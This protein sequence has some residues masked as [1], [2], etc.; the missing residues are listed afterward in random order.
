MVGTCNDIDQLVTT[1]FMNEHFEDFSSQCIDMV[2]AKRK[3][4][5]EYYIF[6][7]AYTKTKDTLYK[8][9]HTY[10]RE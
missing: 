6:E 8:V 10:T 5:E 3:G 4:V 1:E 9:F 2:H 7:R